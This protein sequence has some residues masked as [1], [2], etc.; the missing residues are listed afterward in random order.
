[1]RFAQMSYAA[2]SAAALAWLGRQGTRAVAASIF[3]GLAAPPLAALFKPYIPEAI[4]ALLLLAFLRVD[5]RE[6]R[7]YAMRPGLVLAATAWMMLVTP[8][9]LGG[10]FLALGLRE[11]APGLFLALVLQ[12][13][14]TPL[15]AAPAFVALLGLDAALTL[16]TLALCMV[17][18]PLT[19]PVFAQLFAGDVLTI[20]ATALA[21]KLF[22]LLAGAALVAAVVR[23]LAGAAWVEA[24]RE[25]I[26]GLNVIVLFVFAVAIM[27]GIAARFLADPLLVIG[28]VV[29]AF[30]LTFVLL[31]STALAFA[32]AGRDRAFALGLTAANR[33]LGL[34]LAATGA[35]LP[36][37][38]WLYFGL[39][40]FPIYLAPQILLPLARR[41]ARS[42]PS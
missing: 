23:R 29:L 20:S 39:A 6:L 17:A 28:L 34:M 3:L 14:S 12:A 22:A 18:T 40:Q 31:G 25:K 38:T 4:F 35:T 16:A 37:A 27:D 9:L 32:A 19:A 5:A 2:R 24:Q 1:M 42:R 26:D 11:R 13:S 21:L 15:T 30:M 10:I 8:A 33:N 7:G 36:D 41:V